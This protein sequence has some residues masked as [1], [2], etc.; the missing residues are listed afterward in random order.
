MSNPQEA[1][2]ATVLD[3]VETNQGQ[4]IQRITQETDD[5][6][7]KLQKLFIPGRTLF[8]PTGS[9]ENLEL[10]E[11]V[12]TFL[13]HRPNS[14]DR[15][16]LLAINLSR[17]GIYHFI[18]L[19]FQRGNH[20]NYSAIFICVSG[21]PEQDITLSCNYEDEIYSRKPEKVIEAEEQIKSLDLA[22]KIRMTDSVLA[23]IREQIK[24]A[25]SSQI[26]K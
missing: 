4:E 17:F 6:Y 22:G 9:W 20:R 12:A 13:K 25:K 5:L 18:N 14:D 15:D 23:L 11:P 21:D 3:E 7:Y 10:A 24:I 8:A 26:T 19:S 2:K 1:P 16:C